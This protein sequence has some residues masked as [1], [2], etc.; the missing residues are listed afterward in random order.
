MALVF[1]IASL[2]YLGVCCFFYEEDYFKHMLKTW[3]IPFALV[4]I[5]LL[6]LADKIDVPNFVSLFA[7]IGSASWLVNMIFYHIL[8][9]YSRLHL[10]DDEKSNV[11]ISSYT[12]TIQ[13]PQRSL[14]DDDLKKYEKEDTGKIK[15]LMADISQKIAGLEKYNNDLAEKKRDFKDVAIKT[16][17]TA[18]GSL[19]SNMSYANYYTNYADIKEDYSEKVDALIVAQCDKTVEN[20]NKKI[21]MADETIRSN[22][23]D[24]KKYK[25]MSDKLQKQYDKELKI[26]KIKS[27][28]NSLSEIA[29]EEQNNLDVVTNEMEFNQVVQEFNSLNREIEVRRD[30]EVQY[31]LIDI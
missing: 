17:R 23:N 15:Q 22:K 18:Y 19:V 9:F 10:R 11:N 16:I 26:Q 4:V 31:G 5:V 7:I 6:F 8:K 28:N 25:A 13:T 2:V 29:N 1:I 27:L 21:A 20:V 14:F 3:L 24:I 30:V 12:T